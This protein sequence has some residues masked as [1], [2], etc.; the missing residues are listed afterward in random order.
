MSE[1]PKYIHDML[2]Q[3]RAE[4]QYDC[5]QPD[6]AALCFDVLALVPVCREASDLVYELF[7]VA[8]LRQSQRG[9]AKH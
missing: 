3:A 8:D 6:C 4:G 9:A 1:Y 2:K 5:C 7:C